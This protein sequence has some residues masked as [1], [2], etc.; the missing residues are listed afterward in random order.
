MS[1]DLIGGLSVLGVCASV[2]ILFWAMMNGHFP[3]DHD[4]KWK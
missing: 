3:P 1:M 2:L 4:P